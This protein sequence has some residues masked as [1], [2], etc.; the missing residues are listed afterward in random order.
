[1]HTPLRLIDG[2]VFISDA[3][4]PRHKEALLSLFDTFLSSPPPQLFLMGDIF[5]FLSPY[6]PYT[7]ESNSELIEKINSLSLLCEVVYIEGNHDFLLSSLFKNV[8]VC[9]ISAQPIKLTYGDGKVVAL[10]HGDKYERLRYKI[11]ANLIR[12][13]FVLLLLRVLTFD[14]NG[15]FIKRLY[16]KLLQKNLCRK[17]DGFAQKKQNML[18]K[19]NLSGID[20]LIE[21]HYH[22]RLSMETGNVSYESLSAFACNKSFFKVELKNGKINPVELS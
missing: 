15:R 8:L 17:F 5:E 11:Y 14:L 18:Q 3:H 20:T 10:M 19:Y 2:A 13:P 12:R 16:E 21:G 9:P 6:L 1:M 22:Q 4:Y 7:V